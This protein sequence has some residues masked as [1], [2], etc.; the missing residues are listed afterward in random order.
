MKRFNS[1]KVKGLGKRVLSVLLAVLMAF[2]C[3]ATSLT[4]LADSSIKNV[5]TSSDGHSHH[6][7]K[8]NGKDAFCINYGQESTGKFKTDSAALKYWNSLGTTKKNKIQNALD[9]SK[10]LC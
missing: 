1:Y 5:W 3:F 6:R 7:L 9:T 2:S 4:A 8:V 10:Y